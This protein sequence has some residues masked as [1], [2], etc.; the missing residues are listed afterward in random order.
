MV[1]ILIPMKRFFAD[2]TSET[3]GSYFLHP[4]WGLLGRAPRTPLTPLT[5]AVSLEGVTEE[6]SD[7]VG[8]NSEG[9]ARRYLQGV[10]PDHLSVLEEDRAE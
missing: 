9:D 7:S 6:S 1:S 5:F 4:Q 3:C 2:L 8:R 10:D